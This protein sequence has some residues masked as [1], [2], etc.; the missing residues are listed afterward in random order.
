MQ[1]VINSY[2]LTAF[3]IYMFRDSNIVKVLRRI[4]HNIS[5][6]ISQFKAVYGLIIYPLKYIEHSAP[7]YIK[8]PHAVTFHCVSKPLELISVYL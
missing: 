7:I 5:F 2:M 3:T 1:L 8:V 6:H 4:F